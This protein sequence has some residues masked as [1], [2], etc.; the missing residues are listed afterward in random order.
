MPLYLC[1]MKTGSVPAEAKSKIAQ[2]ITDIH[3]KATDAPAE[4][5][6]V[7]FLE[8]AA[9]PPL[10]DD[11]VYLQGNIRAGRNSAQKDEIIRGMCGS[12]ARHTG[13]GIADIGMQLVDVPASW[14]M[15]GGDVFPEPGEEAAWLEAHAQRLAAE[16]AK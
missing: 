5:V 2:D 6:H 4:F 9:A 10:D 12:I 3:C 13:L 7:F 15:E 11:Q 8:E 16:A 1:N 14:V